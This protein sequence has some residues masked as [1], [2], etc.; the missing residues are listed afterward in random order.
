MNVVAKTNNLI[1]TN[2]FT[3]IEYPI[4]VKSISKFRNITQD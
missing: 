2:L 4:T 3:Q 1:C